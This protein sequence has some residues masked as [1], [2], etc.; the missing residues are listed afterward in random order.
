MAFSTNNRFLRYEEELAL[1]LFFCNVEKFNWL[2]GA[3]CFSASI[4]TEP[5]KIGH[6]ELA[7]YIITA[8]YKKLFNS[9]KYDDL[10]KRNDQIAEILETRYNISLDFEINFNWGK[11]S[12]LYGFVPQKSK[13]AFTNESSYYLVSAISQL[14]L[15]AARKLLVAGANPLEVIKDEK[16]TTYHEFMNHYYCTMDNYNPGKEDWDRMCTSIVNFFPEYVLREQMKEL[17]HHYIPKNIQ[18]NVMKAVE[19]KWNEIKSPYDSN[20]YV[21]DKSLK[22]FLDEIDQPGAVLAITDEDKI[23]SRCGEDIMNA[24]ERVLEYVM[25]DLKY[26]SIRVGGNSFRSGNF[27]ATLMKEKNYP[28]GRFVNLICSN[29]ESRATFTEPNV[30]E[31]DM[32]DFDFKKD[33]EIVEIADKFDI[34]GMQRNE[35]T[36]SLVWFYVNNISTGWFKSDGEFMPFNSNIK[37]LWMLTE[38][39]KIRGFLDMEPASAVLYSDLVPEDSSAIAANVKQLCEDLNIKS[40]DIAQTIDY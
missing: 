3:D 35:S 15:P 27:L 37:G 29:S 28:T 39:A 36:H 26:L 30:R 6:K 19:E 34:R 2:L 21:L 1:S 22:A 20:D 14:D 5:T 32:R 10:R 7:P 9:P 23:T 38:V 25:T 13:N 40:F 16:W 11:D 33:M 4:L 24:Y 31:I 17:L 18:T 8:G 12:P